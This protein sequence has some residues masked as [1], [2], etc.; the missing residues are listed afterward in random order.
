MKL[1]VCTDFQ[2]MHPVCACMCVCYH[3]LLSSQPFGFFTCNVAA[4]SCNGGDS[5]PLVHAAVGILFILR[6]V[7]LRRTAPRLWHHQ[8][9]AVAVSVFFGER[10]GFYFE[11]SILSALVLSLSQSFLWG[12]SIVSVQVRHP[13][14]LT[15]LSFYF[16]DDC[17][18]HSVANWLSG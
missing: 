14:P 3:K 10:G 11:G 17:S 15:S 13:L 6:A 18:F 1:H 9:R 5:K 16:R 2:V 4:V 7:V 12:L 8:L